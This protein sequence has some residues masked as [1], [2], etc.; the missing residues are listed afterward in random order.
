MELRG[1]CPECR[2]LEPSME[3]QVASSRRDGNE[4]LS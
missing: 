1:L 4:V 2:S 3:M